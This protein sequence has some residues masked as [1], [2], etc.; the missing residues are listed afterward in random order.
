MEGTEVQEEVNEERLK[1]GE[2]VEGNF[3]ELQKEILC[4]KI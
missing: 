2:T 4:R 3:I 1:V